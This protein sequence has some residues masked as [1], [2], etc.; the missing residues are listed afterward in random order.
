MVEY[1][2]GNFL[3]TAARSASLILRRVL[4]TTRNLLKTFSPMPCFSNSS[5]EK[6]SVAASKRPP[7]QRYHRA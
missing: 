3:I 6:R 5:R 1:E 7:L 2:A 4:P